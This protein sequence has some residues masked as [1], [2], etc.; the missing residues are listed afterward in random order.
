NSPGGRRSAGCAALIRSVLD[1]SF[2]GLFRR[3]RFHLVAA[4]L[5][6]FA[7]VHHAMLMR[8]PTND[9]FMHLALAR[10]LMA[11]DLPIRD[12]FD[13]GLGLTYVL[14]AV[15]ESIVGYRLLSEALLVGF[16]WALSTWLVFTLVRRLTGSTIAAT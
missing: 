13:S 3:V 15:A 4:L 10:Q 1:M 12:F 2:T 7:L 16:A 11:G 6:A 8:A 9:N 14:S 5:T